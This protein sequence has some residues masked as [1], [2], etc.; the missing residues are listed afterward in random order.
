MTKKKAFND[1][2]KHFFGN[3]NQMLS[4][5]AFRLKI[6]VHFNDKIQI[7]KLLLYITK[8]TIVPASAQSLSWNCWGNLND[9]SLF[10]R[11]KSNIDIHH[12]KYKANTFLVILKGYLRAKL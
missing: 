3:H 10:V 7:M 12:K 8:E 5:I 4:F 2:D 9:C 1:E 11:N 6:I